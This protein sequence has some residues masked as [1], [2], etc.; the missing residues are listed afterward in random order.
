MPCSP[1]PCL[2]ELTQTQEEQRHVS[3]LVS[4]HRPRAGRG[5]LPGCDGPALE[6]VRPWRPTRP[7][8]TLSLPGICSVRVRTVAFH[9]LILITGK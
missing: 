1:L 6:T 7:L 3:Y 9:F 5:E 2:P 8:P 4:P